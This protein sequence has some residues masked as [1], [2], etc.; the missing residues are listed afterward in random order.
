LL[1]RSL[2]HL[3]D[4]DDVEMLS[5]DCSAPRRVLLSSTL[6]DS[7]NVITFYDFDE[8]VVGNLS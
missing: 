6:Y 1:Y 5:T 2:H 8:Y 7:C 3:N 4:T